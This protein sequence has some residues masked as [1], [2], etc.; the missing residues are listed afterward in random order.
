MREIM[1]FIDGVAVKG[2]SGQHGE[3]FNPNTG[4]VQARVALA[5]IKEVDAAVASAVRAQQHWALVNP[6]RRAR[7]MFD[8]KR[9]VEANMNELAEMLSSE[10]GKVIADSKGDVQRGLEVI[11]FACGIP[12][13][14]K[15][16][17]TEGAGPGIDVYSMRQPLGV[18]AGITPFNFPAMIPMWMFGIAIAVGNSFVLKPSEKDPSVPIRLAELMM[19]AGAPKGVLNVINGDKTAV[20]AI[21]EHP[22]I[23]AVSF[24]GSSDIAH[25]VYSRGTAAGKRVQA[26]GGAKN[27]GIVMPDADLDQAVKDIS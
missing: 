2:T 7:V 4:E 23:K 8:F 12:H 15:G 26:M 18:A 21:L 17:Y 11:E 22:D 5:S 25:Y 14:L 13:V 3:V 19:E 1:H 20:D 27:H 6:Q 16:E 9:L 24:V 10:H